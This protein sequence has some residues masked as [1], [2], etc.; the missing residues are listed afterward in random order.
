MRKKAQQPYFFIE[1]NFEFGGKWAQFQTK[2]QKGSKAV[3]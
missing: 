1:K 2:A 3:F